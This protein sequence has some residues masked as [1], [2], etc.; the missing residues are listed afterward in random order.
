MTIRTL[1]LTFNAGTRTLTTRNKGE[2][3]ATNMKNLN[4]D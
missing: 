1:T 3:Q 2:V 4:K